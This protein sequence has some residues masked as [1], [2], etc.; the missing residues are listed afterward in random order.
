MKTFIVLGMHRSATSLVAKGLAQAGINMG[1]HLL[2]AHPSNPYGH[3]EDVEFISINDRILQIAGGSWDNPPEPDKI[4][5]A[6]VVLSGELSEMMARKNQPGLHWGWKDPRTTLTARCFM[7]YLQEPHF[8]T[9]FRNPL[10]VARSLNARDG[11]PVEQGVKLAGTYNQ[12]LIE[13]LGEY[14]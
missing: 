8:I 7:P 14:L 4:L 1:E 12:R 6:G 2:G 10:Q 3:W 13:F 5:G 9:C 11:M